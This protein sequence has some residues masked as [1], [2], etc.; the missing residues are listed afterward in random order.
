VKIIL[1]LAISVIT[2]TILAVSGSHI[3]Q[4]QVVEMYLGASAR[5]LALLVHLSHVEVAVFKRGLIFQ[6][7][8]SIFSKIRNRS[9]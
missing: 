1:S 4:M 6:N 9:L 2:V 7:S 3:R 5:M 8:Q